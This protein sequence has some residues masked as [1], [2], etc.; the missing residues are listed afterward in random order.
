[1]SSHNQIFPSLDEQTLSNSLTTSI[2]ASPPC[3]SAFILGLR[4]SSGLL[5]PN[6]LLLH[7]I[8]SHKRRLRNRP[9]SFYRPK[10][11]G[12]NLFAGF[13]LCR[14]ALSVIPKHAVP[15]GDL[16]GLLPPYENAQHAAIARPMG[17]FNL[18]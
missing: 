9:R 14:I 11:E 13:S 3:A 6:A 12:S 16:L 15:A 10:L 2:V 5:F 1:M 8:P 4:L 17:D 18:A 7:I